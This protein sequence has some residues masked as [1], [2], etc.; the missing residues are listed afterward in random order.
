MIKIKVLDDR[1]LVL[2]NSMDDYLLPDEEELDEFRREDLTNIMP[3]LKLFTPDSLKRIDTLTV[4][5][6]VLDII[7]K[8]DTSSNK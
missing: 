3:V 6:E 8:Q 5:D 4:Q 1:C 7:E 2:P